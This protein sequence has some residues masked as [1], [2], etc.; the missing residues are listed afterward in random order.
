MSDGSARFDEGKYPALFEGAAA[1]R[2]HREAFLAEVPASDLSLDDIC[3]RAQTDPVLDSMKVLG[4]IEAMTSN[5]KVQTRRAF[6]DL[7]ISEAGHIGEVTPEQ[8]AAL[9]ASLEKHAR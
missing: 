3:K 7:G 4:V 8:W 5:G 6:G 9:P 2:A 1:I